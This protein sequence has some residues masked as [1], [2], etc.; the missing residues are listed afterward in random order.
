MWIKST[1]S[2]VELYF[3]DQN[4]NLLL[5]TN[6][7]LC[8]SIFQRTRWRW[9]SFL[10]N[11]FID[12]DDIDDDYELES[13]S[14]SNE[15]ENEEDVTKVE[16]E[17]EQIKEKDVD[18]KNIV[19]GK[20]SNESKNSATIQWKQKFK[21]L[22]DVLNDNNYDNAPPQAECSFEYTDSKK[23]VEMDWK[24]NKDK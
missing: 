16:Q 9:E 3:Q 5:C 17:V 4:E 12:E 21:T 23:K 10:W 19:K 7:M 8:W 2:T 22:G 14:D 1:R 6:K 18:M 24:T 20:A 11:R 13:E 15:A